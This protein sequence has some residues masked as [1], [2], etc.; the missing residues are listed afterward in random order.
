MFP[1][2]Q[3]IVF[4][5]VGVATTVIDFLLFNLL[6]G[7]RLRWKRIPANIISVSVAMLWSFLANWFLVFH[8]SGND[9]VHR[10]GRFLATTAFSAFVLQNLVL[11][12]TSNYWTSPSRVA[13][14]SAKHLRLSL[15]F[16]DDFIARNT[17][18][19]LAVTTGLIW[20]FVWY[21]FFVYAD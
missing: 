15:R 7:P 13:I 20:N 21:K 10:A 18:K 2:Y 4:C 3:F 17:C 16:D 1:A 9:W 6:T 11:Y 12:F 14:A 19:F 5:L 8:P